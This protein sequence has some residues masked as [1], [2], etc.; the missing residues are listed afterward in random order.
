[1]TRRPNI[2]VLTHAVL[3]AA[4]ALLVLILVRSRFYASINFDEEF[5]LWQGWA[6][7]NGNVPYRDFFEPKPP[8]IF[9]ANALG[10]AVFGIKDSLYR[11]V[12][13]AVAVASIALFYPALTARKISPW[14]AALITAQTALWL[15]GGE[16]HDSG[17]NDT[18]T[19]GLAFTLI[20]TSLGAFAAGRAMARG[21]FALQVLSGISFGLAVLCKELFVL[22]VIPAWLLAGITPVDLKWN[23]RQL[24]V[25]AAGGLA[26]G[27]VFLAYL[28][29]N[30]AVGA[31]FDLIGFYRPLAANYCVDLG[32]FPRVSGW[33]VVTASWDM[34]REPLYNVR[35]LAFVV[36]LGAAI[37]LLIRR[38]NARGRL[39]QVLIAFVA[40]VFGMIAVSAGHCFWKHY[41]LMGMAGLLLASIVGAEMLS[42]FLRDKAGWISAVAAVVLTAAL[43]FV[44]APPLRVAL[45]E[46][47]KRHA[48]PWYYEPLL[49]ETIERHSQPG[50]YILSTESPLLYV[51]TNRRNP[52][53]LGAFTDEILPYMSAENRTLQL[54]R[55]RQSL[56]ANL[57]KVIY[58]ASWLR[59]RQEKFH[60]LLFDPLLAKYGY[61]RVTDRIWHLPPAE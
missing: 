29:M 40:V 47:P 13:T 51:A 14:L 39:V 56:E 60:Q 21:T 19:Y 17:L 58:F 35:H 18:E 7:L 46:P 3:L 2:L 54:E 37:P 11:I 57:P 41:F 9:F 50:D 45:E 6:I 10:L 25:S 49:W 36:A 48:Y 33:G 16:F 43:S 28:V 34:L 1:M 31:Y 32:R 8:L 24:I 44:M 20:G 4:L 30:S 15:I 5:F 61:V 53:P 26:V 38:G 55:L 42:Q 27:L 12:P 22:A 59:P 52:L 23:W